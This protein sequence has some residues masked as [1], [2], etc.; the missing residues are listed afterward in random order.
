M[1]ISRYLLVIVLALGI[2]TIF[3]LKAF[4]GGF[5]PFY[6]TNNG[7]RGL[8]IQCSG[9]WDRF[10]CSPN[11]QPGQQHVFFS[12]AQINKF[13]PFGKWHCLSGPTES[14]DPTQECG[15]TSGTSEVKFCIPHDISVNNE[16][17]LTMTDNSLTANFPEKCPKLTTFAHLGDDPKPAAPDRDTFSFEGS[18][19]DEVTLRLEEDTEA[20]HIGEQA[21]LILRDAIG[22]VSFE[23]VR[24]GALPLEIITTLPATGKYSIVVEQHNISQVVR[25]RGDYILSLESSSDTI[26]LIEPTDNV[27]K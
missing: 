5:I 18:G 20:G 15:L 9:P 16:V 17:D 3:P 23:E 4:S 22:G 12:Q 7:D 14:P 24:L 10:E 21:A 26:E 8:C 27:E 2:I 13:S 6:V 1:I 11:I 19:G 25:F